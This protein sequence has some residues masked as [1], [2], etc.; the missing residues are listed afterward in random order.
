MKSAIP[1]RISAVILL[2]I[3][4][5][6]GCGSA[7]TERPTTTPRGPATVVETPQAAGALALTMPNRGDSV[8]FAVLGDFGT[9]TR[10]QYELAAVMKQ[11]HDLFK[12]D[13][14]VLVGDN[15]YGSER[16]QDF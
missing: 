4:V 15:L 8:K 7:S 14:V 3:V 16:P 6:L 12:F 5:V 2:L 10:E 13:F 11:A 1:S 9:G